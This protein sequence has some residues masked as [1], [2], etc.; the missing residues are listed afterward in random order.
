MEIIAIADWG[1]RY[2][3]LGFNYPVNAFPHYLFNWFSESCQVVGQVP[4]KP[5][6]VHQYGSEVWGRCTEAWT[7]MVSIL[8]FWTDKE[9]VRDGVI[10]GGQVH[11]VSAL[12]EYVMETINPYL[13]VNQRVTWEQ[14]VYQTPWMKKWLDAN[15]AEIRKIQRQPILVEGQ[16]S[17]LKMALEMCY[18]QE[19]QNLEEEKVAKSK[20]P[21]PTTPSSS[22]IPSGVGRGQN[23]KLHLKKATQGPR[24]THV[25]PKDLGPDVRKK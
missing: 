4:M 5:D 11:L 13:E 19:L 14:V 22:R 25:E 17:Q 9:S 20:Q 16:S 24:W 21:T 18:Y 23:L 3:E 1:W 8:Q 12:A 7:L 10:F 15:S 2:V 6:S